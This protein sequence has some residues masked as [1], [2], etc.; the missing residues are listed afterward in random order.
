MQKWM[1][2]LMVLIETLYGS[3]Y[4]RVV[5]FSQNFLKL[6]CQIIWISTNFTNATSILFSKPSSYSEKTWFF[7]IKVQGT[8]RLANL[9]LIMS[10]LINFFKYCSIHTKKLHNISLTLF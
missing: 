2:F 4:V 3:I 8:K 6:R 9:G 10:I 1:W 7:S 5:Q